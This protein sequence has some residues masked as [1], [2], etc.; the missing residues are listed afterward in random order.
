M[1]K[2]AMLLLPLLLLAACDSEPAPP[3]SSNPSKPADAGGSE[4]VK[5]YRAAHENKD[6]D[7]L[8]KLVCWDGVEEPM[9]E[10][11]RSGWERDFPLKIH[12][13]ELKPASFRE[14][15]SEYTRNGKTYRPNLEV[16]GWISIVWAKG[17]KAAPTTTDM[18]V[19]M[20]DGNTSITTAAPVR[21]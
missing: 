18:P 17:Q 19:G 11:Y 4:F 21:D 16:T 6:L 12:S 2:Q 9:R 8:M 13:I 20:K 14:I 7:A 5:Q 10:M 3:P 15:V 1:T